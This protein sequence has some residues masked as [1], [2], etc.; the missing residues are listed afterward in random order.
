M[1]GYSESSFYEACDC[2]FTMGTLTLSQLTKRGIVG[3]EQA[4]QI[5]MWLVQQSVKFII[6]VGF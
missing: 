4:R 2:N 6:F 1:W 3:H 5:L